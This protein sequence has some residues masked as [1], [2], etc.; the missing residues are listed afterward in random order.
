MAKMTYP[1]A[2]VNGKNGRLKN[3]GKLTDVIKNWSRTLG[4]NRIAEKFDTRYFEDY[5]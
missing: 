5:L 1:K 2:V 4:S 3:G